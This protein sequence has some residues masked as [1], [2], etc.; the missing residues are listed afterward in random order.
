VE[1]RASSGTTEAGM[2]ETIGIDRE[3]MV[4]LG[5]SLF[6]ID[7]K[8]ALSLIALTA[9]AAVALVD[10]PPPAGSIAILVRNRVRVFCT[11]ASIDASR[12]ALAFDDP[13]QG[14]RMEDFTGIPQAG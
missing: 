2:S 5:A 3:T 1:E 6:S 11:V 8:L 4:L 10:V 7:G 12:I 9:E 13:L 14:W